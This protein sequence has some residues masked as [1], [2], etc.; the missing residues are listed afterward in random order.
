MALLL[1][2]VLR[3][4][5]VPGA[6]L[7]AAI[8]A[9]HPV[10]VESVAWITEFKNTFSAVFYL[11]TMLAYLDFDHSRRPR[12]YAWALVLFV[13]SLLAKTTTATLPAAML[14][15]FWWKRGRLSWKQD[16]RPLL[17]FFA[18][19]FA[20][21]LFVAWWEHTVIGAHGRDFNFSLF[22]RCLIAGHAVWFYL[23]KLFW[24]Q[25][26][27]FFYPQWNLS[28]HRL[29]QCLYVV[30]AVALLAVLWQLRNRWR[31]PLAAYLFYV[32]TLLPLLGFS[33]A[34]LFK[35]TFVADHFQYLASMGMIALVAGVVTQAFHGAPALKGGAGTGGGTV[36]ILVSAK[37][38]LSPSPAQVFR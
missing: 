29:V 14:V 24:P 21:G 32:G 5:R 8:F 36:P 31:A 22:Q 15:I 11:A 17:P 1:A 12:A 25:N 4:L 13:L 35:Y 28:Q 16:V 34:V 19:A 33:N 27:V 23:G 30:A 3:R 37:M 10:E 6:F 20:F 18:V 2:E 9:L 26:L 38:G 7:A